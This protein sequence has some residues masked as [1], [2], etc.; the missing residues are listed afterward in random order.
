MLQ[1]EAGE[2]WRLRSVRG[3]RARLATPQ[4]AL[5]RDKGLGEAAL[6]PSGMVAPSALPIFFDVL[7]V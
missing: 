4:E 6:A 1:A 7:E 3:G 2:L 5:L